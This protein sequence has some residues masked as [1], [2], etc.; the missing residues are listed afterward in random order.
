MTLSA[1]RPPLRVAATLALLAFAAPGLLMAQTQAPPAPKAEVAPAVAPEPAE[2][3]AKTET[4]KATPPAPTPPA[5]PGAPTFPNA[6]SAKYASQTAGRA[7]MH[8]CRD[9]YQANKA[10][11]GNGGLKWIQK[12]GGYYSQCLKKLKT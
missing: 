7:R 12:G 9:Q 2:P 6:V 1:V 10:A 8:T 5:P 3:P 11:H 4:A